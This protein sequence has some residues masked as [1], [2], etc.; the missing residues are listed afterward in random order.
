MEMDAM[1]RPPRIALC[2]PGRCGKDTAA[3]WLHENTRLNYVMSTSE[4][5]APVAAE[6]LGLTVE[7]AFARR[8]EDRA[9]WCR[10]GKEMRASDPAFL[11]R[12][13]L[14]K[15]SDIVVGVRDRQEIVTASLE[16]LVDL[17]VWIDRRVPFDPTLEYGPELCDIRITND[18]SLDEFHGKLAA[19]ARFA[20]LETVSSRIGPRPGTL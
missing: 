14:D 17:V 16:G 19:L 6:R 10:L 11:V 7:A 5:I 3:E 9:L 20:R 12:T 1:S 18:D 13:V 15:G 4:V 2:G 8:H